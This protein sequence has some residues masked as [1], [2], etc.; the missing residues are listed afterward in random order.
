MAYEFERDEFRYGDRY[1]REENRRSME[2]ERA[3]DDAR[4]E[5]DRLERRQEP[6]E[7]LAA[8]VN[9][10]DIIID[11]KMVKVINDPALAMDRNGSVMK[12][13][14]PQKTKITMGR[15]P[16]YLPPKFKRTRRKTKMDKTMSKCLQEAQRKNRNKNGKL[17]KGKT[18]VDVMKMA[19]KLCRKEMGT[20]KGMVR[21]T[22]R[23]AYMKK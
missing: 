7:R 6:A 17:K 21:K 10:P 1:L 15:G 12:R 8:V 5:L 19:H 2:R 16:L 9:D 11:P 20:R 3:M 23:R 18:M 13:I 14:T 22:A 4:R